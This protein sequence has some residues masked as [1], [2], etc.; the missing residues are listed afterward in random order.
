MDSNLNRM[1]IIYMLKR[2]IIFMRIFYL[3][4]HFIFKILKFVKKLQFKNIN[5]LNF[6]ITMKIQ[7]KLLL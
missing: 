7:N 3:I 1:N 2:K 5:F 6:M 4:V